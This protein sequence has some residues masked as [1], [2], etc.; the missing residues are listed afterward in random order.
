MLGMIAA[1]PLF[2]SGDQRLGRLMN[3]GSG[4]WTVAPDL[5]QAGMPPLCLHLGREANPLAQLQCR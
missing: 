3:R 4:E 5:P 1:S 2:P